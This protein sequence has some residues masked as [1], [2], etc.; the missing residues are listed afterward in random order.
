MGENKGEAGV[1]GGEL[2][3]NPDL[4]T[5]NQRR[6]LRWPRITTLNCLMGSLCHYSDIYQYTDSSQLFMKTILHWINHSSN[7]ND[8]EPC[9]ELTLL[10]FGLDKSKPKYVTLH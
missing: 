9:E 3:V 8:T 6:R 10:Y 5:Y 1:E 2:L 7:R 4:M